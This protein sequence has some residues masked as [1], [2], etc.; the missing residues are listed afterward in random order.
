[1]AKNLEK[2]NAKKNCR[3]LS[4]A[5]GESI[6]QAI[7]AFKKKHTFVFFNLGQKRELIGS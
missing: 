5:K 7:E 3:E 6:K 2:Q 1:M 4:C